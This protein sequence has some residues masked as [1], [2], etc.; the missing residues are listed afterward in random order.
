MTRKAESAEKD[1]AVA[2]R[3]AA[4]T[5]GLGI[6]AILVSL[7]RFRWANFRHRLKSLS[8]C[9]P[10]H[11]SFVSNA[12]AEAEGPPIAT[13]SPPNRPCPFRHWTKGGRWRQPLSIIA[14]RASA[15]ATAGMGLVQ[16]LL[17]PAAIGRPI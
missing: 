13:L 16:K 1:A 11:A 12:T 10:H 6:S 15:R 3:N 14:T 7:S 9:S 4:I 2:D 5:S 17:P 8:A